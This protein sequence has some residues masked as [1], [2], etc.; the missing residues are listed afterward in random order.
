MQW[1]KNELLEKKYVNKGKKIDRKVFFTVTLILLLAISA[2]MASGSTVKAQTTSTP[3]NWVNL[4]T[5]TPGGAWRPETGVT[6]YP[7]ESSLAGDLQ[8][9]AFSAGPAPL[10]NHTLWRDQIP[11]GLW[12]NFLV[13]N[14]TVVFASALNNAVYCVDQNTGKE[15]WHTSLV[16]DSWGGGWIQAV[17]SELLFTEETTM[18]TYVLEGQ[19][20]IVRLKFPDQGRVA[21]A[22]PMGTVFKDGA[23]V[24]TQQY[25]PTRPDIYNIGQG[26]AC[27]KLTS[28]GTTFM[29]NKTTTQGLL[30]YNNGFLYGEK[31]LGTWCSCV[32]A[33]TGDLVWNFTGTGDPKDTF[34][35][36]P[37]ITNG[38][39]IMSTT[40]GNHVIAI[41][42]A[43]GKY[44]W[45]FT[46]E[47]SFVQ[48][49][50]AGYG[51]IYVTGGSEN[52][53]Y[54]INASGSLLWS[55]IAPGIVDFN[56]VEVANGAIYAVSASMT[57]P[58]FA[59]SG[60][61]SGYTLCINATTGKEIWRSLTPTAC[62]DVWVADGNLYTN[63]FNDYVFCWGAGPTT[64]AISAA[65]TYISS[66]Q[67][68]TLSG[69]VTDIS[70]FSQEH[71]NL[72]SPMVGGVP[73]VLSYVKDGAWTDFATVNTNSDGTFIYSWTP[74]SAGNYKVVA[75]FEGNDAYYWSSAQQIVQVNQATPQTSTSSPASASPGTSPIISGSLSASVSP[76]GQ[77]ESPTSTGTASMSIYIAIA[78]V[79]VV[80]AVIAAALVLRKRSK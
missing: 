52:K 80:L 79:V 73:V 39:I 45:T 8:K 48:C 57:I 47:G 68:I 26:I 72:Q 69:S 4:I 78:V 23:A 21:L 50:A 74:P 10:S 62:T 19:T 59:I 33:T 54:C 11:V 61:Y 14:G 66:G 34:Y 60:T 6:Q 12:T 18:T 63:G 46:T 2:L 53:I 41:N 22:C 58:G 27:Y 71:P 51:N 44:E 30:S 3:Q 75:R 28:S 5:Q 64:T 36:N 9:T 13:T 25:D 17:G 65:S 55:Y 70:P 77:V 15:I 76:S 32:N 43:T 20:G 49:I 38:L 40:P 7:R 56:P 37:V 35:T 42:A 16:T 67:A 31:V 24:F 1:R 29:W